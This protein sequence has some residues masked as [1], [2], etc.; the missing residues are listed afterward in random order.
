MKS[1]VC[2]YWVVGLFLTVGLQELACQKSLTHQNLWWAGYYNTLVFNDRWYLFTEFEN[3]RFFEPSVQHQAFVR[4]HMHR[5]FSNGWDV[6]AGLAYFGTWPDNPEAENSI[7][8][9]EFRQH[10]EAIQRH[11]MG[12]ISVDHRYRLESR[13]FRNVNADRSELEPGYTFGAFRFRYR[14]QFVVPLWTLKNERPLVFKVND[15]LHIN[16]GE[17]IRYNVFDQNRFYLGLGHSIL[18]NVFVEI[19][20][21]RWFQ[22][23][24]TGVDFFTRNIIRLSVFHRI[25]V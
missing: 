3:R 2:R 5:V 20:Y 9:P 23:R 19:G 16:I 8:V 21:L 11:N 12:R 14:L 4:S 24:I 1:L 15:E 13:F 18:P 17:K 7:A 22:Q 6:S 10:L 25:E